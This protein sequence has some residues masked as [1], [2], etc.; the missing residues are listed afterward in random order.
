MTNSPFR[1]IVLIL[2]KRNG[3]MGISLFDDFVLGVS[4]ISS[5]LPLSFLSRYTVLSILITAKSVWESLPTTVAV[6]SVLFLLKVGDNF[7]FVIVNFDNV[8]SSDHFT[9]DYLNI[10]SSYNVSDESLFNKHINEL[11]DKYDL[12][13]NNEIFTNLKRKC[14]DII[15][16]IETKVNMYCFLSVA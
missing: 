5:Q 3:G 7:P 2:S 12:L 6:Y 8:L 11:K 16:N 15:D 14:D 13:Y 4:I 9:K 1:G 10:A